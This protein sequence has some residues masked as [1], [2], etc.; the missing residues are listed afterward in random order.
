MEQA[1]YDLRDY[2]FSE[3]GPAEKAEMERWLARSPAGREELDRLRSTEQAL[4]SV[5]AEEPPRR[6]AFVSDKVFEPTPWARLLGRL[7]EGAPRLGFS[8]AAVLAVL[9]VGLWQ[10]QPTIMKDADGF[11]VAFGAPPAAAAPSPAV[12]APALGKAGILSVVEEAL[13]ASAAE[14]RDAAAELAAAR[15][16]E[17]EQR[18]EVKLDEQREDTEVVLGLIRK[19]FESLYKALALVEQAEAR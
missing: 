18:W 16:A 8:F 3:L 12:A 13:A 2:L 15:L 6:I 5:A 9:F 1:P 10:T 7:G 4:L 17:V 11:R 14:S 19:N